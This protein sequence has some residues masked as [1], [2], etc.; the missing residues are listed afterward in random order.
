MDY[1]KIRD[2]L[3]PDNH[4]EHLQ[5][6]GVVDYAKIRDSLVPDN[7]GEHLQPRGVV[8]YHSALW[9]CQ[10]MKGIDL[11]SNPGGAIFLKT[12]SPPGRTFLAGNS[13]IQI[14]RNL[15]K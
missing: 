2:S 15:F 9:A 10:G 14:K 11:G 3:V 5:P 13:F 7:H 12:Y 6:R 1:A 4:G 8:D